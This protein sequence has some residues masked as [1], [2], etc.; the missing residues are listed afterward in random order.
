MKKQIVR[1]IYRE[2]DSWV[3]QFSLS[4]RKGCTAC[5]TRDVTLTAVEAELIIDYLKVNKQEDWLAGKL[6]GDLPRIAPSCTTNEYAQHCLEEKDIEP[7]PAVNGGICPFLEDGACKIYH[8]RPFSCRSFASTTLCRPGKSAV[9]PPHYLT[10]VTAVSQVIEHLGQRYYWG[11]MLHI[12]YLLAQQDE[13]TADMAYP[14]NKKRMVLAQ[15]SCRTS[16]PLPGFLIPEEDYPPVERLLNT[17][18]ESTVEGKRIEDI[19]NNR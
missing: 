6:D 1:S 5:C 8:V 17:I 16:Q 14:E 10:A 19:L 2:F 13:R 7:D 15:S 18:F 4:C 11:N 9:A 12:I 3:E